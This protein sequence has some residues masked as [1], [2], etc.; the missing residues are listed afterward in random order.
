MR[1]KNSSSREVLYLNDKK[2]IERDKDN[3]LFEG[4]ET[5]KLPKNEMSIT[6]LR[7]EP[8]IKPLYDGFSRI[9]RRRFFADD[10]ER[11]SAFQVM[12]KKHMSEI[13]LKNDLEELYKADLGLNL[14]LFYS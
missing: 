4:R 14:G 11:N 2:I 1:E 3:F 6:T 10:I 12:N 5:I 13:G 7:E 8:L 9:L